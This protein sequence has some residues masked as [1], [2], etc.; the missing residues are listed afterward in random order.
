MFQEC[1]EGNNAESHVV[2]Q[3]LSNLSPNDSDIPDMNYYSTCF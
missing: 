3:V 1:Q 2:I